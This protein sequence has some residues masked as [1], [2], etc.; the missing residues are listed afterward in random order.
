MKITKKNLEAAFPGEDTDT[1]FD[2]IVSR[3]KLIAFARKH[4]ESDQQIISADPIVIM[5]EAWERKK[6]WENEVE[7]MLECLDLVLKTCGIEYL[8]DKED[9]QH[10]RMG[11]SYLNTGDTYTPTVIHD[12]RKSVTL[13]SDWGTIVENN[14]KRFGQG[15]K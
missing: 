8:E 3:P 6:I 5:L 4:E 10:E 14:P 13:I 1:A 15:A 2:L 11:I 7:L 9:T 12:W